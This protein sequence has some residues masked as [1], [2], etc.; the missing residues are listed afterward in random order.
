LFNPA[1]HNLAL[2]FLYH[3]QLKTADSWLEKMRRLGIWSA[4]S[5]EKCCQT[6][7]LHSSTVN[8]FLGLIRD[9]R[10]MFQEG[11]V[12]QVTREKG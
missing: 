3:S 2:T 10:A 11:H 6:G 4:M 1:Q 9:D 12:V 7:Y 5:K 8:I